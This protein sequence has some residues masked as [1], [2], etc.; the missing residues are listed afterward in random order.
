MRFIIPFFLL[1]SLQ[2]LASICTKESIVK[3]NQL[4][5]QAD[6]EYNKTRQIELLEN[7]LNACYAPEIEASLLVVKAETSTDIHKQIAYY[8]DVLGLL[9]D[10]GDVSKAIYFQN[11]YNLKLAI[12]Y[13]PIDKE[14]S[15]DYRRRGRDTQS[16]EKSKRFEYGVY[17]LFILLLGWSI[18]GVFRKK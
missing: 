14:T 11:I 4:Y 9:S 18:F 16:K 15:D 12:L 2:L 6:N 7:A 10:F 8:T 3:S 13:E 1:F 5:K 17:F